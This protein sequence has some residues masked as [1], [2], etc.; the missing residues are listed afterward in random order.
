MFRLLVLSLAAALVS[1]PYPALA[2]VRTA[3]PAERGLSIADFPRLVPLGDGVY[4]YEALRKPG[5]T[6]VSMFVVGADGVLIADGQETPD[7]TRALLAA[8]ATVTDKPVRWMVVGSVHEDHTGG[9]SALPASTVLVVHPDGFSQIKS[10]GRKVER[11]PGAIGETKSIDL[12]NRIVEILFLG[13]AHTASDLVVR[14]PD[15]NLVF[16]SEVFMNRVF[17][18]MRSAFPTEWEDALQRAFDLKA[19]RYVPG[20]GFVDGPER[21]LEEMQAFR[22]AMAHIRSEARRLCGLSTGEREADWG[23]YASW[24]LAESQGPIALHRISTLRE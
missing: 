6:T 23:E 7:A 9:M 14:V 19:D 10:G 24:M 17:P 16:M 20:H 11:G 13:K 1:L 15:Q 5:F 12:G 22:S 8:V 4:A 3:Y 18:P 21:S 2:Q